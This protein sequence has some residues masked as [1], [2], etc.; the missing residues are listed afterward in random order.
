MKLYE[1][2]AKTLLKEAGIAIPKSQLLSKPSE[3]LKL[4]GRVIGKAQVLFGGRG[5]KGLISPN[6]KELFEK[7]GVEKV[8]VEEFVDSQ[9]LFFV[10]VTYSTDSRTPVVLYSYHGGIDIEDQKK[11][12]ILPIDLTCDSL[13]AV[14]KVNEVVKKLWDLFKKI[15]ARLIEI[16]PLVQAKTGFVALDAKIILDDDALFRHQ[17]LEFEPRSELKSKPTQFEVA[18]KKID[19]ND[20]RGSAGSSYFDLDGDI[21]VIAAGGGGSVVNMD[22]LIALGCKPANY[23]EHS[24]NPPAEK[25]EKLTKIVLS[26]PNLAGVWFVG[27]TANFTDMVE[28]LTG[29]VSGLRSVKPKPTYPIVIRRGGPRWEEAK[30]MLEEVR[31]KEGFDLHIFGP[32]TPMTST[33]KV[34]V[35]LVQEFKT[36]DRSLKRHASMR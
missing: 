16:N 31:K 7:S 14:P 32:E 4:E 24:G 3:T 11:I 5:K 23:T 1:F 13:P 26:K 25:V 33:A 8:L 15:D 6:Y 22:A 17:E 28:T 35:D 19:E 36:R 10:S 21:A 30:E 12:N 27:A 18:A 20:H 9:K 34:M 29:F 2:E